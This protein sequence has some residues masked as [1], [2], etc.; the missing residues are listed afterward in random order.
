MIVAE[1]D[2]VIPTVSINNKVNEIIE[3]GRCDC[4]AIWVDYNLIDDIMLMNG[5]DFELHYKCNL[6]FFSKPINVTQTSILHSNVIFE[7]GDSDF[8]FDFNIM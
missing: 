4:V 6:K 1:L 8:I 3:N 5:K 2:Y 7:N